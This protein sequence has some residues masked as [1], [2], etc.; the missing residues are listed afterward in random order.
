TPDDPGAADLRFTINSTTGAR[1]ISPYVYGMN[2]Y[3]NSSFDRALLPAQLER[4]G[5]N[6]WSAYN[7][8]TNA[9][10]AGKDYRYQNDNYLVNNAS[11]TA[12]GAAVLASLQGAAAK[13]RALIVTVPTAGWASADANGQPVTLA[14][15]GKLGRFRE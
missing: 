9:S 13:D 1:E 11:N 7:W 12:P 6:R 14:Q 8:E 10:N 3:N 15:A 2:F 5:G 4:L